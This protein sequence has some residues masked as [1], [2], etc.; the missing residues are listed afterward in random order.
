MGLL[1]QLIDC[2]VATW[3]CL[4]ILLIGYAALLVTTFIE[5]C[6]FTKAVIST[7][8]NSIKDKK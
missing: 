1:T 8:Y 7:A 6:K 5:A 3:A 2:I 4:V